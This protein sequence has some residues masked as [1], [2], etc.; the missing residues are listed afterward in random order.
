MSQDLAIYICEHNSDTYE[1]TVT[2]W[3]GAPDGGYQFTFTD[4]KSQG[5]PTARCFSIS[6]KQ[7]EHL[8]KLHLMRKIDG[9]EQMDFHRHLEEVIDYRGLEL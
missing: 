8:Y 1:V 6:G 3:S 7:L 9:L 4:K 5:K 2:A